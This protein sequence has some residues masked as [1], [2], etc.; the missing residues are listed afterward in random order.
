MG[1]IGE[2]VLVGGKLSMSQRCQPIVKK[3]NVKMCC[4]NGRVVGDT[5]GNLSPLH[6]ISRNL[7][8]TLSSWTQHSMRQSGSG[9]KKNNCG[10]GSVTWRKTE[11]LFKITE[12]KP[13]EDIITIRNCIKS[14]CKEKRS[15]AFSLSTGNTMRSSR[16]EQVYRKCSLYIGERHWSIGTY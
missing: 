1:W 15:Q 11:G 8:D 7:N 10:L 16:P 2:G 9:P 12:R 6:G 14:S 13:V 5:W 3:A 4:G